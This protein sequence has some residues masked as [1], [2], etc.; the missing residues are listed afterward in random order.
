M[1]TSSQE[2]KKRIFELE[3]DSARLKDDLTRDITNPLAERDST[4][5]VLKNTISDLEKQIQ[6]SCQEE[7]ALLNLDNLR[8]V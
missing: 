2:L 1:C 8:Q 6:E 4:I 3:E 7:S 5:A